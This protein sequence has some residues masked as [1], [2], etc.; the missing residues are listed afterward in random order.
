MGIETANNL[1][2]IIA[3]FSTIETT[4]TRRFEVEGSNYIY[5]S[6]DYRRTGHFLAPIGADAAGKAV[7][8][9]APHHFFDDEVRELN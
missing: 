7:F 8:V 1:E 3:Y 4:N 5:A 9:D 2:R 6:Y